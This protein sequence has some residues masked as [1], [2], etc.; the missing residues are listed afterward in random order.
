MSIF[1]NCDLCNSLNSQ[2]KLKKNKIILV[3]QKR[4]RKHNF[5]DVEK[6]ITYGELIVSK[7]KT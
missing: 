4:E 1:L 3:K 7:S 2:N 6:E 5:I